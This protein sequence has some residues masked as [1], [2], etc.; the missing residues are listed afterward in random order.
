MSD[1]FIKNKVVCERLGVSN[2]QRLQLIEQGLLEQP[3]NFG[4]AYPTHT[5]QQ[6]IRAQ[7]RIEEKARNLVNQLSSMKPIFSAKEQELIRANA[8]HIR[9]KI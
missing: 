1:K 9:V 5:E 6:V 4:G 3:I 8:K 7:K 2:Y